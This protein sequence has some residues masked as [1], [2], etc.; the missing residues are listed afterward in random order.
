MCHSTLRE[1]PRNSEDG[2]HLAH[3]AS[4]KPQAASKTIS[5]R[6]PEVSLHHLESVVELKTPK[7]RPRA[8]Q[9]SNWV[10]L[11]LSFVLDF[12]PSGFEFTF[13]LAQAFIYVW[14]DYWMIFKN[15][16]SKRYQ[17]DIRFLDVLELESPKSRTLPVSNLV[18]LGLKFHLNVG[19]SG[20]A[21]YNFSWCF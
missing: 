2:Y 12:G 9:L 20:L 11:D 18:P 17:E 3:T 4:E 8:L 6:F 5:G 19:P 21:F 15:T 16:C 1:F 7:S 13:F 10:P 14:I